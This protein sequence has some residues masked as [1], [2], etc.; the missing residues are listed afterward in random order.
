MR[1]FFRY[2]LFNL[3]LLGFFLAFADFLQ[4]A[5][6][7]SLIVKG[8]GPAPH[9]NLGQRKYR[10]KSAIFHHGI[11]PLSGPHLESWGFDPFWNFS[12]QYGL[13]SGSADMK[14]YPD[15]FTLVMGDS[16]AEGVGVNFEKVFSSYLPG[17]VKNVGVIS[18]SPVLQGARLEW[19]EA[20][21]PNPSRLVWLIDPSDVIDEYNYR[22]VE[23]F[24]PPSEITY[25]M[26]GQHLADMNAIPGLGLDDVQVLEDR[27]PGFWRVLK[28][29]LMFP[30]F[31]LGLFGANHP[32]ELLASRDCENFLSSDK[33]KWV[34]LKCYNRLRRVWAVTSH[35]D[36]SYV[37]NESAPLI[38]AAVERQL[39]R[40]PSRRIDL[41]F[42]LWP[43][44]ITKRESPGG[45]Y[46][47]LVGKFRVLADRYQSLR[48]CDL[49]GLIKPQEV[50]ALFIAGDVHWNVKGH[51]KIAGGIAKC[52]S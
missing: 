25:Q 34:S 10:A 48:I 12:D 52:L 43:D 32:K 35:P 14:T 3:V 8:F 38:Y 30:R 46:R 17:N 37:I 27:L 47:S 24:I 23:G 44:Q 20:L 5:F 19:L 28:M 42:Y 36:I 49:T 11:V 45:P 22:F 26:A 29:N 15:H 2:L 9:Y 31:F 33:S 39:M 41:V 40:N 18:H 16:F 1:G 7:S 50:G 6:R 4:A 21:G 13:R 51:Q